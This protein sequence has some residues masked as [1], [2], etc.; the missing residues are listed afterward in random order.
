MTNPE[1]KGQINSLSG[2]EENW[3]FTKPASIADLR[4]GF[5]N[6]SSTPGSHY[7]INEIVTAA[8]PEEEGTTDKKKGK[9]RGKAK[10][11]GKGKGKEKT[12]TR[13]QPKKTRSKRKKDNKTEDSDKK[14]SKKKAKK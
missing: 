3:K 13:K 12:T 11:K 9:K 1:I 5:Q 10:P 14:H 7:T 4:K 2:M 6:V 8:L